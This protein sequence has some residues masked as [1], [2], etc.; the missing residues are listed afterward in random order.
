MC[1]TI[2]KITINFLSQLNFESDPIV[3]F[4]I[5]KHMCPQLED[6]L[7]ILRDRFLAEKYDIKVFFYLIGAHVLD[8]CDTDTYGLEQAVD[9]IKG[10]K[11]TY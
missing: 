4:V 3:I 2:T 7:H 11:I 6:V 8:D 1:L 9:F 5:V 10:K